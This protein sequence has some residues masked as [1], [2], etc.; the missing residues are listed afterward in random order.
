MLETRE[1]SRDWQAEEAQV[2]RRGGR[3][4]SCRGQE[5]RAGLAV[6]ATVRTDIEGKISRTKGARSARKP[7]SMGGQLDP[8][9]GFEADEFLARAGLVLCEAGENGRNQVNCSYPAGMRESGK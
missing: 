1:E 5:R 9:R 4:R 3:Q 8:E 6:A 2:V 7:F